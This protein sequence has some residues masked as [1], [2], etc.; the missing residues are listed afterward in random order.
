MES[1][2]SRTRPRSALVKSPAFEGEAK[3]RGFES[4]ER[5]LRSPRP[6]FAEF[7]VSVA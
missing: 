6:I 1:A 3:G 2:V 7:L 4:G 5:Y